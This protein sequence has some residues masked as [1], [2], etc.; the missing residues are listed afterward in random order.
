[1]RGVDDGY[2]FHMAVSG[3]GAYPILAAENGLHIFE[4]PE[5]EGKSFRRSLARVRVFPQPP[6]PAI[7]GS[8]NC[9]SRHSSHC[10]RAFLTG[11][12]S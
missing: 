3:L 10:P 1:M 2:Y 4:A 12:R 7:Q 6:E 11:L 5:T 8:A 9:G